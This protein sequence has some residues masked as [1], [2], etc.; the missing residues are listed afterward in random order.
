MNVLGAF[1]SFR[2]A[3]FDQLH[4]PV[5]IGI[6]V[7]V[8]V[9]NWLINFDIYFTIDVAQKYLWQGFLFVQYGLPAIIFSFALFKKHKQ[10]ERPAGISLRGQ[11]SIPESKRI[12]L[13][14]DGVLDKGGQAE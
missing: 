13:T 14:R 6:V 5:A 4:I 1:Y 7:L 2:M 12:T 9:V 3:F 10:K 11:K 8:Y